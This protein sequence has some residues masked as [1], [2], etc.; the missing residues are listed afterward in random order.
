[1]TADPRS[2]YAVSID[3]ARETI[4]ARARHYKRLVMVVSLGIVTAMVMALY[5]RSAWPLLALGLLPPLVLAHHAADLRSVH[6]WRDQ[7]IERWTRAELDLVLLATTLGK[8]P[9]LPA[10]T[11][12]GMLDSLPAWPLSKAH[13]ASPS[14]RD[15]LQSTQQ[16]L[17]RLAE[18]ALLAR[19][20]A[21]AAALTGGALLLAGERWAGLAA[22]TVAAAM[23]P[24]WN[25]WAAARVRRVAARLSEG[26]RDAA[27]F[28]WNGVP[29]RLR[30]AWPQASR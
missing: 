25:G 23:V 27:R 17:G 14:A 11:V 21:W 22:A 6:R 24:A 10:L 1:M 20:F 15:D 13:D 28:N 9:A 8:V 29:D 7:A 12:Q 3:E 19:A 30:Q 26:S 2:P 16:A 4:V 5:L 18:Q